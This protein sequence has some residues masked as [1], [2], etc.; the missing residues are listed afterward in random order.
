MKL[1][2]PVADLQKK[3]LFVATPMYGGQCFGSYTKSILD[4]SR[5]AQAYG[6]N[7]SHLSLT[8]R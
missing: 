4:L 8:N 7:N 2:V 5:V 1:E 3:S 6:V